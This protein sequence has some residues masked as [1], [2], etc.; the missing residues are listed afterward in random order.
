MGS[1]AQDAEPDHEQ[2]ARTIALRLLTHAPRSRHQLAEAMV[3]RGV[4]DDVVERVLDRFV[5]VG[6]IDDAAYAE[7]LVRTRV[8]ERG[9]A[10]RAI[11]VELRRRG[12]GDLE[13][14]AALGVVDEA[15]EEA[16]ARALLERRWPRAGGLDPVTAARRMSAMLGRKGYPSGLVARLVREMGDRMRDDGQVPPWSMDGDVD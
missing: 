1:A 8:S 13:A 9:Q 5:E 11:A 10:R 14:A 16:A 15:A 6:L 3:A 4:P 12:I 7:M 2:V